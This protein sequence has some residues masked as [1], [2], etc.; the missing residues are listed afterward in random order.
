MAECSESMGRTH[1]SGLAIGS[2]GRAARDSGPRARR[3]RHHQV[4][5][6]DERLLVGGR[7]DLAGPQ[8]G[9]HR[10]EADDAA[11]GHDDHVH[12]RVAVANASMASGSGSATVPGGQR[13]ARQ[14]CRV[15]ERDHAGRTCRDLCGERGRVAAGGHR[16][17]PECVRAGAG[18]H[19]EGLAP[20]RARSSPGARRGPGRPRSRS[21]PS[22]SS[23][24]RNANSAGAANRNES[25]A[26]QDAAVAGDERARSP[27]GR[28]RA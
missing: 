28:R 13:E 10:P 1:A 24:I 22:G 15:R 18:E 3:E 12:V 17:D 2:P 5:A 4:A 9:E 8:R 27:S 21:S 7:D 6:R 19:V 26:I 25:V 23:A 16:D 11:G 14:G 20:D